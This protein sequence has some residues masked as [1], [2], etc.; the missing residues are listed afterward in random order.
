VLVAASECFFRAFAFNALPEL[1]FLLA[2]PV[3]GSC[4][5]IQR[6]L[7]DD[8][9]DAPL[10]CGSTGCTKRCRNRCR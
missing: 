5:S 8:E 9:S 2:A 7:S 10:R 4:S 1:A 6:E 3:L